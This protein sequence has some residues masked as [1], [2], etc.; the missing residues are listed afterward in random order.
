LK[1]S[2]QNFKHVTLKEVKPIL[3]K[4][5]SIPS[6]SGNEHEIAE[7]VEKYL[8]KLGFQIEKIQM[9]GCGPTILACYEFKPDGLNLL[10]YGHLDTVKPS[11]GWK[12]PPFKP[13]VVDGF[14]Y[15][16]GACDMKGG[17]SAILTA[18]EK[19]VR[20]KLTGRLTVAL[21]SDE[22]SY[23]RGC[24]GLI[25]SGKLKNVDAA[26]SA[27]PTGLTRM[28]IGRVGRIVYEV[29]FQGMA[30]HVS[31]LDGGVNVLVDAS[32]F[33]LGL[34]RSRFGRKKLSVLTMNGGTEFLSVPDSCKLLVDGKLGLGESEKT[35]L[36]WMFKLAHKLNLKSSFK[37]KI[38]KRP[39][40]YMKPYLLSEREKIVKVVEQACLIVK[41]IK[42][43][44]VV[45]FSVG[46]ENY[47]VVRAKIPTVTIG[48]EGGNEHGPNEYVK[49]N[50]VVD[51]ANIYV[52]TALIFLGN[53]KI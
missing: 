9:F 15:G 25:R 43:R 35:I 39:T 30:R 27:E 38:F 20:S 6:V 37:V 51:A 52:A 19:L 41:G 26:V 23:S 5:V 40:P 33:V 45:G 44:K 31:A 48:P 46:D 24:D 10:F 13:T 7:Y 12:Y 49:L 34:N 11:L 8:S 22:E 32:K 42:P 1:L 17:V 14:L 53:S 3:K 2:F 28:E 21:T 50:S 16:L 47:L 29:T 4:L 18:V 36:D